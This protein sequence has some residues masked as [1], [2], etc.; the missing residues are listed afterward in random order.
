MDIVVGYTLGQGIVL[1][2]RVRSCTRINLHHPS[3][4]PKVQLD[5]GLRWRMSARRYVQ[6]GLSPRSKS[7]NLVSM[8]ACGSEV[9]W[10]P[11]QE[12]VKARN[13]KGDSIAPNMARK[14]SRSKG[15]KMQPAITDLSFTIP[16]GGGTTTDA[17]SYID[18]AKEL[19]K[20]NRRLYS[21]SRMYGYQGL[22][23]IW[24]AAADAGTQQ[25]SS[26]QCSVRTAGNTWVVQNAHTKGHALWNQMQELVL[27]DNPSVAGKWHDFKCLLSLQ[28]VQTRVLGCED[29]AGNP[30]LDG[31]WNTSTYVMPQHEVDGAGNPKPA[32]EFD[33]VLIGDDTG[34]TNKRSLVKAYQESRATVFPDAPNTP[35]ALTTSFFN[36]LTDSGSQEPE[37]ATV[38]RDENDNPPYSL[39]EYPGGA[40][41]GGVPVTVGYGAISPTEVDGRIGGFIAPC[42]LLEIEIIGYDQYGVQFPVASMPEIGLLLHVAPGSYKG[43]AAIPMGQ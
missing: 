42:G 1:S 22:T 11:N 40:V 13:Y 33:A 38:I 7:S 23:F 28:H 43:V 15:M 14:K 34:S 26:I 4:G 24:R 25:L 10:L 3:I 32:D 20:C 6:W 19:S 16:A 12:G 29:G 18:T 37:L 36:L 21:Q 17:R 41:N 39:D 2:R 31:E 9:N 8:R 5:D 30:Y 27:E 35:V